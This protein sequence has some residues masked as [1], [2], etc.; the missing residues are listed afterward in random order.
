MA[1]VCYGQCVL[2]PLCVIDDR[3]QIG[4]IVCS[5]AD[6][7]PCFMTKPGIVGSSK[8]LPSTENGVLGIFS[9]N[10]FHSINFV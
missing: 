7:N 2:W 3:G 6:Q 9:M 8:A 4:Y 10:T 5:T 1:T